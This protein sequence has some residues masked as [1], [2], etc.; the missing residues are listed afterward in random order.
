MFVDSHAHLEGHKYDSDRA[1]VFARAAQAGVNSVLCIG[2]SDTPDGFD[3]AIKLAEQFPNVYASVGIHPHEAKL[4]NEELYAHLAE[5]A[6]QPKIIGWGEI[7]LDY[8]YDHSPRDVQRAAFIRQMELA[9]PACLPIIIHCRPSDNSDNAWQE[10]FARIREHWFGQSE[11]GGIIHCFTGEP[12]H[13]LEA[14]D[15]GF[16]VSFS[17]AVTFPKAENIRAAARE[18]PLDRILVETD[19]PYLAP[20]PYRGK[21][22]EPAYVVETAKKIAEVRGVSVDEIAR[23]TTDNFHRFFKLQPPHLSSRTNA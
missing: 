1:D 9:R 2:N 21:R 14:V 16:M 23:A 12:K 5:L 18:C 10:V 8:Y 4:G 13:M 6:K 20:I 3:C 22:N 17:G 11:R 7:G 15:L 19:S